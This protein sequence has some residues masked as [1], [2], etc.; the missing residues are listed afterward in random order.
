M[1]KNFS[2]R[3]IVDG[4]AQDVV[5]TTEMAEDVYSVYQK[6]LNKDMIREAADKAVHDGRMSR[7]L[8]EKLNSEE[9]LDAVETEFEEALCSD[10]CRTLDIANDVVA[11]WIESNIE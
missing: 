9:E 3:A 7:E 1:K 8:R 6:E 10:F 5:M 11:R 2:A 4:L